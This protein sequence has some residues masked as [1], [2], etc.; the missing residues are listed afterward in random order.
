MAPGQHQSVQWDGAEIFLHFPHPGWLS[1][2][3][4][5][6][7]NSASSD[8]GNPV[9]VLTLSRQRSLHQVRVEVVVVRE[10][11]VGQV[12]LAGLFSRNTECR[13]VGEQSVPLGV[14]PEQSDVVTI[15][16]VRGIHPVQLQSPLVTSSIPVD[17]G[18]AVDCQENLK[19]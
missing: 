16:H 8:V 11:L 17:L 7:Q 4:V 15:S 10:L 6:G 12:I 1:L 3:T 19:I 9:V 2:Q 14:P 18:Q 5:D 13:L